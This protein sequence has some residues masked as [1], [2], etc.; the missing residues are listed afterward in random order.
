M[1]AAQGFGLKTRQC[2]P[3]QASIQFS[4]VVKLDVSA[5]FG[6]LICGFSLFE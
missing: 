1:T 5:D 6:E 2:M 3:E 4:A